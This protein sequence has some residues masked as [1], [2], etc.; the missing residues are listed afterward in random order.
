MIA[1]ILSLNIGGPKEIE[2]NWKTITTS[3]HKLPVEG[4]LMVHKD[5]IEG[6][7]FSNPQ[8]HGTLDSILYIYGLTSAQKFAERLGLEKYTPGSTGETLTVDHFDETL[9]GVGDIFQIGEVK[10]QATY[11]RIPCGKVNF[12]MQ[13]SEGQKAMQECG[14]SGVYFRIL[15]EGKIKKT[16]E[17]K[18]IEPAKHRYTIFDLYP[19]MI[20]NLPPTQEEFEIMKANGA[21]PQRIVEK[22][23]KHMEGS[24]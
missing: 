5:H 12:R 19:K 7:T 11:P 8:F 16:D 14:L 4:P 3:M 24:S 21:F 18:L 23:T 15:K 17:V 10:A 22:W 1:K 6:N 2:W 13:H 20:K 9:I